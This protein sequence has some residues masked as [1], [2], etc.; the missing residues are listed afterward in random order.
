MCSFSLR[1]SG[2]G[3]KIGPVCACVCLSVCER[4]HGW[5]V[6][7]TDP[8]F[9]GGIDVVNTSISDGFEGQGHRQR[10]RSPGW[11]NVISEVSDRWITQSQFVMTPDVMWC[12]GT[13]PWHH[14]TSWYDVMTS[15][16]DILTSF[17]DFWARILT[18]RARRGRVH[19]HPGIFIISNIYFNLTHSSFRY[20]AKLKAEAAMIHDGCN[21]HVRNI[22]K[23]VTYLP[24]SPAFS[25]ALP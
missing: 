19:Q 1:V 15:W 20:A 22:L 4:S 11:K 18:K 9:G 24:P 6:W 5:T 13:T 23:C 21:F 14:V 17:D 10:S 3:Y 7:H 8:K 2:R 16:H 25:L 12:H